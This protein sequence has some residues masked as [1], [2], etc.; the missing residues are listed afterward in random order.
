[1]GEPRTDRDFPNDLKSFPRHSRD[2]PADFGKDL[3]QTPPDFGKTFPDKLLVSLC[4][5]EPPASKLYQA[6]AWK[7]GWSAMNIVPPF[8]H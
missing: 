5:P 4:L 8:L 6:I 7:S 3:P 1:M 2:L